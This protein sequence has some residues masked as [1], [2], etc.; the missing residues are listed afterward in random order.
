MRTFADWFL[1][2][3]AIGAAALL[4]LIVL[5][6]MFESRKKKLDDQVVR[7]NRAER[8]KDNAD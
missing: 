1:N 4:L 6:S 2:I 5:R 7:K 8:F 3:V